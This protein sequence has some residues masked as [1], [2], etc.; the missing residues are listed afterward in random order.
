MSRWVRRSLLIGGAVLGVGLFV[1]ILVSRR[2]PEHLLYQGKTVRAWAGQLYAPDQRVRDEASAALK[3]MGPRAV[4][5]LVKMLQAKDSIFRK[6]AWSIPR[7]VP[8]RLRV[9]VGR[10]VR[11]P[12]A[13]FLRDSAARALAAIGPDAK[14]AVP[15][16]AQAL[17]DDAREVRDDA[18]VALGRIGEAAVTELVNALA[19]K[20]PEIRCNSAYALGAA[21]Q[22]AKR[23]VPAL[24][25]RLKEGGD[26]PIRQHCRPVG[27]WSGRGAGV[28]S[29]NWARA[30]PRATSRGE[31][32]DAAR[33][34][35]EAGRT[36]TAADD[37]G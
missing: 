7:A 33:C 37:A 6:L 23:A 18:A 26:G 15:A 31:G 19:D 17:H 9:L 28:A 3:A 2:S 4:P 16:L 11:M 32:V 35:A 12:D 1:G 34:L 30:W 14:A 20:S 13:A 8:R 27:D 22:A 24:M 29:R 25:A 21:G 5:E 36:A 10:N